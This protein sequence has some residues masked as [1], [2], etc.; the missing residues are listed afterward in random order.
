MIAAALRSIEAAMAAAR[1][2]VHDE[3]DV[4]RD[5]M[6]TNFPQSLKL[7]PLT[8]NVRRELGAVSFAM[9]LGKP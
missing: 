8:I 7:V 6:D 9:P 2:R 4:Q 3:T 1:R 5:N